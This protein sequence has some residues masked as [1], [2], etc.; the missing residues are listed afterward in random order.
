MIV[1]AVIA[2]IRAGL[3]FS[4]NPLDW[5]A[6]S[7]SLVLLVGANAAIVALGAADYRWV[8]LDL[9][10]RLEGSPL[11]KA[12]QAI[13][14]LHEKNWGGAAEIADELARNLP[15]WPWIRAFH[16]HVSAAAG[17][18]D[19][20]LLQIEAA[21]RL[22]PSSPWWQLSH[23]ELLLEL[24]RYADALALVEGVDPSTVGRAPL[25][26]LRG[27]ALYGLGRREEAIL[28]FTSAVE[29]EPGE[30]AHRIRR[31]RAIVDVSN[32]ASTAEPTSALLEIVLDDGERVAVQ[33]VVRAGRNSL[34]ARDVEQAIE[35]FTFALDREADVDTLFL[36]AFA[37]YR[38]GQRELAEEDFEAA[39]NLGARPEDIHTERATALASVGS[40]K[41]S[42]D[43]LTAALVIRPSGDRHYRRAM[44]R[45]RSNQ[46]A[47]ALEDFEQA[48][49]RDPGNVDAKAHRAEALARLGRYDDAETAFG[50]AAATGEHVAHT[51]EVWLKSLL[52]T[53][54]EGDAEGVVVRALHERLSEESRSRLLAVAGTIYARLKLFNRA[55]DVLNEAE[56]LTPNSPNIAYRRAT[57]YLDM[58]DVSAALEA[59]EPAIREHWSLR[60]AALA[61]RSSIFRMQKDSASALAD[62]TSAIH[63]QPEEPRLLVSRA[64]LNMED[65][66]LTIALQ[67]LDR[68]LALRASH[69]A[70]LSHRI[71]ARAQLGDADGALEDLKL[72]ESLDPN[73]TALLHAQ[74]SYWS[75]LSDWNEV[76]KVRRRLL[77]LNPGDPSRTWNLAAAYVNL[78][79][80]AEAEIL[81]GAL[82]K[83]GSSPVQADLSHAVAISMQGRSDEAQA[84]FAEARKMHAEDADRWMESSL[85]RDLLP[86]YD[87]VI[88]D[89][90]ATEASHRESG[91][92]P[93]SE[94]DF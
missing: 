58:G 48:L 46:N 14:M 12:T 3:A 52:A 63:L 73:E 51:Y 10:K 77:N 27:A 22:E 92:P 29:L 7:A 2:G 90:E 37:R 69:P 4:L 40:M 75:G 60:V 47:P 57:C 41:A 21:R 31:G 71:R 19:S 45:L 55:L 54:R 30:A 82:R 81:F 24:D 61:T 36:R 38:A 50:E 88:D 26:S 6:E 56:S 59:I 32:R 93:S 8:S 44:I 42:Q 5:T 74:D 35:D 72:F 13:E 80:P 67:D 28:A 65:G 64:C 43:E 66:R 20:A 16:A 70:A 68:A 91:E 49:V 85:R 83:E 23:T 39:R 78:D 17:E 89:W 86:R 53:G 62:I 33:T 18:L 1:I 94:R 11:S 9:V 76:V 84:L 87:Q 15:S 34:R 79:Q 25:S